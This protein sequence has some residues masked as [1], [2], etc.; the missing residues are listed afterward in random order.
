MNGDELKHGTSPVAAAQKLRLRG[1]PLYTVPVGSQKRL[2]DLDL[3][4]VT[5]PTYGII[6]ENVQIVPVPE[7]FAELQEHPDHRRV[8][9]LIDGLFLL[10]RERR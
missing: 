2:P 5:A 7:F 6:G 9:Q 4:T 10:V 1:V 8:R 3:L